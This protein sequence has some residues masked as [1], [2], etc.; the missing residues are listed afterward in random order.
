MAGVMLRQLAI[1][2]GIGSLAFTIITPQPTFAAPTIT[3]KANFAGTN[4]S[5]PAAALT[6]AGNGLFYGTTIRGGDNNVGSIFEFDP[7]GVGSITLKASFDGASGANPESSL[8]PAGN[9]LYYG[10]TVLGGS[11]GVGSIIEFDPFGGG[12][13]TLKASFDGANGAQPY[14]TLTPAGNGRFYGTAAFGGDIGFGTIF[15]FDP[16]GTGSITLKASFDGANGAVPN[17]ALTPANNGLFYG[18]TTYGGDNNI[19]SIFEFDPS[20][21]GSI[22]LKGS[23]DGTNG[24]TPY[25]ALIPADN[26]LF[27]GTAYSGGDIGVGSIFEFDPSGGGSITLKASF[28]LANGAYPFAGLAPAGNGLFYGTTVVGGSNGVGSIFEFDPSGGGSITL[29]ASFNTEGVPGGELLQT[30]D[31]IFFGITSNGG[32]LG[33]GTIYEF[34]PMPAT[35]VPGPLPLLGAAAAFS[36]SRR[37]RRRIQQVRDHVHDRPIK[38]RTPQ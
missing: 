14:A 17:A 18:T 20:G 10:T 23:F 11:N 31:G 7:S 12:S 13:I 4:G 30:I 36:W 27:Y 22:S 19:G 33:I 32:D 37:L 29:K 5:D 16:S 25:A 9:G 28:D 26:G 2:G 8:T 34:D 15:E 24:A 21:S 3:V 35:P 1:M 38:S 6:P